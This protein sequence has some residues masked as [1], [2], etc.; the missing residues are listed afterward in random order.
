MVASGLL[1]PV[2]SQVMF[3]QRRSTFSSGFTTMLA[4]AQRIWL[5]HSKINVD[6]A[7]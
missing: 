7:K 4:E 5:G 2:A 6:T 1:S 3:A